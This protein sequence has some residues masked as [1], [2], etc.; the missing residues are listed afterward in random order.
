[1]R[2]MKILG[3][4]TGN[5]VELC[6]TVN[7]KVSEQTVRALM[8]EHIPFTKN[9]K[10]IPFFRRDDYKGAEELWVIK[11][12]PRRY[13]QARRTIDGL[14]RIYREKLVLSNY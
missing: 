9:C 10:R 2:S 5:D 13:S 3:K 7:A 14:D 11:V 12:N 4:Y 1:M 8:A 6:K